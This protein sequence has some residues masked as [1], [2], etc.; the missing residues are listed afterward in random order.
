MVQDVNVYLADLPKK[1]LAEEA[2][3]IRVALQLWFER[4]VARHKLDAKVRVSWAPDPPAIRDRDLL[5]YFVMNVG[6]SIVGGNSIAKDVVPP[7]SNWGITVN[8]GTTVGS[9]VYQNRPKVA[10]HAARLAMHELMHN[11]G[12]AGGSMHRPGMSIGAEEVIEDAIL[13]D[14]DMKWIATHLLKTGRTQWSGGW[15]KYSSPLRF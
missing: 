13:S 6:D 1:Y 5:C 8:K 2:E 4:V 11:M 7:A 14:G 9:E 10:G 15:S 12:L 3:Q